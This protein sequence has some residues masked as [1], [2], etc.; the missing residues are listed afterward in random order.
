VRQSLLATGSDPAQ[1]KLDLTESVALDDMD[2]VVSRRCSRTWFG[3]AGIGY[4]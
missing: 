3:S 4:Y 1:L 2:T